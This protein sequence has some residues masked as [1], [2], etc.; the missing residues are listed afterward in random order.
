MSTEIGVAWGRE[1]ADKP[2]QGSGLTDKAHVTRFSG[3]P[4]GTC[5]QVT[6]DD[7]FVQFDRD[8]VSRMRK[9]LGLAYEDI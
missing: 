8:G 2:S 3:G 1:H 5:V 4:D 7:K 6:I 9:L